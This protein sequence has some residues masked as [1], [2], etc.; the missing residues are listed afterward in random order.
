[1]ILARSFFQISKGKVTTPDVK[2]IFIELIACHSISSPKK[3]I[4]K[5]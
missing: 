5:C 2:N 1:M 3:Y 4:Q